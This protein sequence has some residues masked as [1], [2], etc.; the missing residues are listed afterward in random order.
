MISEN[1]DSENGVNGTQTSSEGVS[2]G[3][4]PPVEQPKPDRK[5][6]TARQKWTKEINK[7]VMKCNLKSDP[8]KRGYRK[9][10]LAFWNLELEI[11]K[12]KRRKS[13]GTREVTA[14]KPNFSKL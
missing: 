6:A 12:I 3:T 2:P 1:T 11:E 10:M 8:S 9:R 4:D 13:E 5:P 14:W 7:I